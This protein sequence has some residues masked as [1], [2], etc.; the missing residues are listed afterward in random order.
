MKGPLGSGLDHGL[1]DNADLNSSLD[2]FTFY[3]KSSPRDPTGHFYFFLK[4][5]SK[6]QYNG[7]CLLDR[8]QAT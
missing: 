3:Q 5:L 6:S 8:K 1:R 4:G 2:C 7:A